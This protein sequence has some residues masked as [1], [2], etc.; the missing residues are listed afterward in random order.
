MIKLPLFYWLEY[1]NFDYKNRSIDSYL[2]FKDVIK[3]YHTGEKESRSVC[4][5]LD[6]NDKYI[7]TLPEEVYFI[8]GN[9]GGANKNWYPT[10]QTIVT[11]STNNNSNVF[12]PYTS[13]VSGSSYPK[14]I[15]GNNGPVGPTGVQ[16]YY[17]PK[18]LKL[19]FEQVEH[20]LWIIEE[21][22][23]ITI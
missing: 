20:N 18:K 8:Y 14:G 2:L 13:V 1:N 7:I 15:S 3:F 16:G 4:Y 17:N 12:V 5:W 22:R 10:P 11:S 19:T 6:N 21:P 23:M 9:S